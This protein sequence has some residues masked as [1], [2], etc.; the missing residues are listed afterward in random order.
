MKLNISIILVF[1]L[2]TSGCVYYNTFF[3]AEKY[4]DEAQEMELNDNGKPT[5]NAIQKYKKVIKKCGIV[6]EYYEDSKYSDDALLLMARS[7]FYIG[8]NYTQTISTLEDMIKFY[9][10]SKLVPDAKLYIARAKYE[11][12]QEEEAYV[13]LHE[14]LTDNDLKEHHPKAL[15]ILANYKLQ[16]NDYVQTDYYLNK[17]IEEYPDSDEYEEAFFL[18]GKSQNEA[19]NYDKSNE[20]FLKL[21]KSKVTKKT[22][23]NA[24]YYIALNYLLMEEYQQA[25]D[26]ATKLLK[27][28]Y[29]DNKISQIRLVQARSYAELDNIDDAVALLEAI[30][31]DNRQTSLSA[32]AFYFLGEI[33]FH[34]LKEYSTAI[35]FYNKVRLEDRD[36]EYLENSILQS[37]ITS[38]IIQY[39]NPTSTIS[40]EELINQQ[41]KLAEFYIEY[42]EMPDSALI[43]YDDI[44]LQEDKFSTAIDTIQI[45]LDSLFV[46]IDSLEMADSLQ[47]ITKPDS[48]KYDE[49]EEVDS[50]KVNLYAEYNSLKLLLKNAKENISL[51]QKEFVPFAKFTKLW[52]YKKVIIDSIKADIIYDE[53]L[54]NYPDNKYTYAAE[55]FLAGKDSIVIATRKQIKETA[56][57]NFAIHYVET[58]PEK[59]VEF[60]IPIT[61]NNQHEYRL[62]AFYSLGY[63]NYF[64]LIDSLSAKPYFDSVLAYTENSEYKTEISK[65]YDGNNFIKISRLPFIEHMIQAEL[66]KDKAELEEEVKEKKKAEENKD[67]EKE[68][69]SERLP[70]EKEEPNQ[71]PSIK[72]KDK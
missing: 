50:Q 51:Y 10:E 7:F 68:N 56:E 35:E 13:L 53:L 25:A 52:L 47:Q 43:V 1:V 23:F 9:P 38:Q 57:Y 54:T 17:L 3:N 65:F 34:K 30:T 70:E 5:S 28:E 20:I 48:V 22:K 33:H 29:R 64:V 26:Y 8:R 42:L 72:D 37:V 40:A 45:K 31:E 41:F 2:V 63:I 16:E 32:Q 15:K 27:D 12:R 11:F 67:P 14:F 66:D 18:Q 61:N 39:Y 69:V 46:I 6:L 21:L 4:F 44:I 62:Q 55:Q 24:K 36:S 49:K 71:Q 58:Q 60:L 19:G 59:S